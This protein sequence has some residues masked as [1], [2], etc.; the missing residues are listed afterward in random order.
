MQNVQ[1]YRR[2]DSFFA[3][4]KSFFRWLF[5]MYA[6][7]VTVLFVGSSM[8]Y[9]ETKAQLAESSEA[10]ESLTMEVVALAAA[11]DVCEKTI[12]EA[13]IP[14]ATVSAALSKHV[15]E[16]VEVFGDKAMQEVY[17][18]WDSMLSLY[19]KAK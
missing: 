9:V 7:V 10:V 18:M 16:P 19:E 15:V 3:A 14:E 12:K 8:L 6:A 2:S 11:R 1:V 5:W 17:R 13:L 4:L